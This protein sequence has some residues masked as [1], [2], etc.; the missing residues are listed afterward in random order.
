MIRILNYLPLGSSL[1]LCRHK[2]K[3]L[4]SVKESYIHLIQNNATN[5]YIRSSSMSAFRS[6]CSRYKFRLGHLFRSVSGVYIL[7]SVRRKKLVGMSKKISAV[8]C[9]FEAFYNSKAG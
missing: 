8:S 2:E 5:Y 3:N 6:A 9:N 1:V 4:D 7:R